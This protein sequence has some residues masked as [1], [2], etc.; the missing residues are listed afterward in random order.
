MKAVL[1]GKFIVLSAPVKKLEKSYTTN[2]IA[3]LKA[4]EQKESNTHKR[5]K[6]QKIIKFMV[7]ISQ[8]ET[9]RIIKESTNPRTG[10]LRKSTR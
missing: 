10:S 8:F 6:W 5:S 4:L 3:L 2:L 9:R 7:E 1:R